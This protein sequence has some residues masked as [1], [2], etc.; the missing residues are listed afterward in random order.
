MRQYTFDSDNHYTGFLDSDTFIENSTAVAPETDEHKLWNI[1]TS[2]WEIVPP[3]EI[4]LDIAKIDKIDEARDYFNEMIMSFESNAAEFEL[5][6][7]ETQRSEWVRYVA[8][9]TATT[10]YCDTLANTRGINRDDLM[11]KIGAK[12]VGVATVQGNLHKLEDVINACTT[13]DD[14]YAISW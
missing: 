10:P 2:V 6:T 1:D 12:V 5:A 7:W 11:A 9:N 4:T 8:D 13:I 3:V 14:V